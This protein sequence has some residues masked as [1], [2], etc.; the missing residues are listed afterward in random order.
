MK[1]SLFILVRGV[2]SLSTVYCLLPTEVFAQDSLNVRRIGSV[3]LSTIAHEVIVSGN[4]A[5]VANLTADLLIL[6]FLGVGVEEREVNEKSTM[7]NEKI[8]LLQNQPNPFQSSTLIRYQIP[9][10]PFHK[11][12]IKGD[13]SNV[14]LAINNISGRLVETLVNERQEPGVYH[15]P[16]T[17]HQ[18]PIS[19][20]GALQEQSHRKDL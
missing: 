10:S 3:D 8:E 13:L 14:R 15:L 5:Y 9:L 7:K 6:E 20:Y 11:G 19:A 12:G 16:I 17:I 18:L 2:F 4:Y 1:R